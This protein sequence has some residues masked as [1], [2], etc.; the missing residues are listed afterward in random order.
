LCIMYF[1]IQNNTIVTMNTFISLAE[2]LSQK[3]VKRKMNKIMYLQMFSQSSTPH[4]RP[5]VPCARSE[6][7]PRRPSYKSGTTNLRSS[8][9]ICGS[10]FTEAPGINRIKFIKQNY[11]N[12]ALTS[13][14]ARLLTDETNSD[15][16]NWMD[17]HGY[18]IRVN[19]RHPRNPCST[20]AS[21]FV[22]APYSKYSDRI[23]RINPSTNPVNPVHPVQSGSSFSAAPDI[24]CSVFIKN[25]TSQNSRR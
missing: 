3:L 8:A 7:V 13:K 10:V 25:R 2:K 16:T 6:P 9:F 19:P 12:S 5:L 24:N 23:N 15:N 22:D 18:E 1:V 20:S 11:L 17:L 21:L 4:W 14:P